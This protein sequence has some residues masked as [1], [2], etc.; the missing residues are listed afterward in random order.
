MAILGQDGRGKMEAK[1]K[2]LGFRRWSLGGVGFL[3]PSYYVP[4]RRKK[5]KTISRRARRGRRDSN[6]SLPVRGRQWITCLA[7]SHS[8]VRKSEEGD[9]LKTE[10]KDVLIIGISVAISANTG[11]APG[12]RNGD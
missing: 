5:K 7:L 1:E 3:R 10:V 2:M 11:K 4:V 12:R 6:F 9:S 8:P